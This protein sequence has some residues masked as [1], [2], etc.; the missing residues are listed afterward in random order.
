MGAFQPALTAL[1]NDKNLIQ[2]DDELGNEITLLAGQINAATYRFLKLIAEFDRRDAWSGAGIRSCAH[3]LSWK[4]GIAVGAAREKVRVANCLNELPETNKAFAKGEISYSKVR[5]MTRIATNEN[6]SF[7]L[8]IAR[9]GT[10]SHMEQLVSKSKIIVNN[11]QQSNS[12]EQER[13][14]QERS[15]ISFQDDDGMW[16]IHAKLPAEAG[17]LVDKAIDA[18]LAEH[19]QQ[20]EQSSGKD[21]SAE[22][23]SDEDTDEDELTEEPTFPQKRVDALGAMAEHYLA[24]AKN[25][26]GIKYLA[27]NERTQVMLHVDINTLQQ[28]NTHHN[29]HKE[30][31]NLNN[32][33]WITPETAK[34]LS[35]DAS[36]VTVLE[37]DKGNVLNIGRRSRVIPPNI[38][39]ALK[40]RDTSCQFP[41]C[42]SRDY[43][44]AHHIKHWADGGETKMDNLM[45]LCR[46]HHRELHKGVF[47]IETTDSGYE[48]NPA[49]GK[50]MKQ[51][52]FP[53]FPTL[54]QADSVAW[55]KEQ[56]PDIDEHTAVSQWQGETMDIDMAFGGLGLL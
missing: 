5:A 14:Q 26:E 38:Q 40:I 51:E 46:F 36:L 6:E 11:H 17:A 13:H 16:H 32:K 1:S 52:F 20:T 34:R 54:K 2:S 41:G 27:G 12:S 45:M 8:M 39:R 19:E 50:T 24:T 37:D 10:A 49:K 42:C 43:L 25:G 48:F 30:H 7:M 44:D 33:H 21:V 15:M 23:F 28:H 9:H 22:T 29:T 53:Q 31:C 4:C 47:S 56:Y 55:F 3:W 35:C 18:I